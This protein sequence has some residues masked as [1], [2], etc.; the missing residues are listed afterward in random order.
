M[1]RKDLV[2]WFSQVGKEDVAL[3]GGKGANLGE[4]TQAGFPVPNGFI[5]TANAYYQFIKDNNLAIKIDHLLKTTHF[6]RSDSLMDVSNH[7]KKLILTSGISPDLVQEIYNAYKMLGGAFKN[8]LVAVR[9]SAT[10][11]DLPNASFAGQQETYLNV[12]GEANVI[13]AIKKAWASLFEPR[14][15]FYRHE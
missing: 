4:M 1:S 9:S 14:A 12:H 11:E 15:I 5:V 2:V 8:A 13:I 3:V 10:A 6:E 7:I